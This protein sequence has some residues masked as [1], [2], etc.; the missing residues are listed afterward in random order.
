[1][2]EVQKLV[3]QML[4]GNR[5]DLE[6]TIRGFMTGEVPFTKEAAGQMLQQILFSQWDE[7]KGIF[8]RFCFWCWRPLFWEIYP[9]LLKAGRLERLHF[10]FC[11]CFCLCF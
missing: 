11:I 7:E 4:E 5:F 8:F 6:E 9:E 2:Q 10:I 1:M 3:D